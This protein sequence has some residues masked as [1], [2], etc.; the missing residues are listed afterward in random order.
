MSNAKWKELFTLVSEANVRIVRANWKFLHDSQTY[1]WVGFPSTHDLLEEGLR[2]G[3]WQ[4]IHYKDIEHIEIPRK[5]P[6]PM[7]DPQNP[8]PVITQPIME[9][10]GVLE[11]HGGFSLYFNDDG[12]VIKGCKS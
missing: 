11:C 3:V 7:E 9:V 8:L 1:E 4:P 2:D 6:N 12:L 5:C 10:K